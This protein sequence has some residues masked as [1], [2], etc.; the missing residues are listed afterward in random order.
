[1]FWQRES[2]YVCSNKNMCVFVWQRVKR[3]V[4]EYS[5]WDGVTHSSP[6]RMPTK[7]SAHSTN[8]MSPTLLIQVSLT[9]AF[10]WM[11]L[12]RDLWVC[13]C[14]FGQCYN[15]IGMWLKP[16]VMTGRGKAIAPLTPIAISVLSLAFILSFFLS[17]SPSSH[18][19]V[20]GLRNNRVGSWRTF[21]PL[22]SNH[23]YQTSLS[24]V[25]FSIFQLLICFLSLHSLPHQ[26]SAMAL[27]ANKWH[28]LKTYY[29]YVFV[30]PSPPNSLQVRLKLL[31]CRSSRQLC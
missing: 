5:F 30:C 18:P 28:A 14:S 26:S 7:T 2:G 13:V 27:Q 22:Q 20:T 1:M 16:F 24:F 15:R 8:V 10:N 3:R 23:S 19:S 9:K 17:L 6:W 11:Y 4:S 31:H 25:S 12:F 21:T 29:F